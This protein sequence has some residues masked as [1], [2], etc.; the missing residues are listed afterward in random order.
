[1]KRCLEIAVL[2]LLCVVVAGCNPSK[3]EPIW[4]HVKIGD[5]APWKS[6]Q[7]GGI[8]GIKSIYWGYQVYR[9]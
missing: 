2:G 1:M 8:G 3:E 6:D 7:R 4:E 9:L 5:L